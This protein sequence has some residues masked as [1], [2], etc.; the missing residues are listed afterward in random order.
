[1]RMIRVRVDDADF[2]YLTTASFNHKQ[3]L[4][5]FVRD[6]LHAWVADD[7]RPDPE[8]SDLSDT[9]A[10]VPSKVDPAMPSGRVGRPT[11]EQWERLNKWLTATG[12]VPEESEHIKTKSA[13]LAWAVREGFQP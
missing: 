3:S 1:M 13:L 2:D 10:P 7:T 5:G 12:R 8:V 4:A 11:A 9:P 6:L